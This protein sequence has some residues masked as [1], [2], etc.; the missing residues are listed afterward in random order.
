MERILPAS[1]ANATAQNM[2]WICPRHMVTI[3]VSDAV[4]LVLYVKIYYNV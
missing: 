2:R 4:K 3:I 1:I